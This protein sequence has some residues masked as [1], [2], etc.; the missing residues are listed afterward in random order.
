[1][2]ICPADEGNPQ[3]AAG[4]ADRVQPADGNHLEEPGGDGGMKWE[5]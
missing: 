1:M 5:R 4:I 3:G 2:W